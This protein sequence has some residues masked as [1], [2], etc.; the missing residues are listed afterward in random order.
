MSDLFEF[1]D[2]QIRVLAERL[3]RYLGHQLTDPEMVKAAESVL[4]AWEA[5]P[6]EARGA[7]AVAYEGVLWHAVW[8]IYHLADEEHRKDGVTNPALHECLHLLESRA[9][10]PQHYVARRPEA[11]A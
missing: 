3:R 4:D 1:V 2:G 8:T 10:L 6:D 9:P 7:D 11:Q 5:L